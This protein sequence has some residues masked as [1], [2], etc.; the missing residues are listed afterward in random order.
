MPP[1]LPKRRKI[2]PAIEEITFD[3][4]ARQDYLSG[5]HKR[6]QQRIRHAKDDAVKR[7]RDTKLE[8][9]KQVRW[10]FLPS[11]NG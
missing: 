9:R 10:L 2:A 4:A 11:L 5:F 6:K 3:P 7:D 8:A 1:P